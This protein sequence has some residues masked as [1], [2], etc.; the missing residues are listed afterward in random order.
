MVSNHTNVLHHNILGILATMKRMERRV[1]V[2]LFND[3]LHQKRSCA[4]NLIYAYL[5][6]PQVMIIGPE[7]TLTMITNGLKSEP[8]TK[9]DCFFPKVQIIS[10]TINICSRKRSTEHYSKVVTAMVG[11]LTMLQ[12]GSLRTMQSFR[13]IVLRMMG[14]NQFQMVKWS[15]SFASFLRLD[16]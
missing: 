6:V 3:I 11:A 10:L 5:F 7:F 1:Q 14:D 8:L 2:S 9:I 15:T 4:H 13:R 16:M 12:I